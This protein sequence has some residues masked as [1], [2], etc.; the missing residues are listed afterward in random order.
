VTGV[1]DTPA[2][3]DGAQIVN[4]TVA[5][6]AAGS[7]NAWDSLAA[8]QVAVTN[9]DNDAPGFTLSKT[10]AAVSENGTTDTFTVV[11]NAQPLSNV[12]LDVSSANTDEVTASPAQVTFTP[13]N[14]D[15]PVIITV[16][17][18]ND[19][20][21]VV[22]GAQVVNVT[23]AVNAA[24]SDNAWDSLAAQQ[25]AVTNADNDAPGFTL[26]KTTA[27][28]SENGT[29]DTFTVVLNAQPLSN[30]VLD[31]SSANTDEVTASPAQVTFTPSNWDTPVIITV[32][33][34][35]DTPAVVDGAQ[36]VNVTVAVNA[37]GSDNAWD[38]LAAQQ[39][40][41]TNADNDAPGFTLSK[42]TAAVSENGTTDTFTVVLNAQPLS[43][44]VLDVSSANTDEV[45]AAPAQV[46][47][48]PSNWDTPV[49]ITVTG[50]NDT[51]AVV[52]GAQVVN[53]TVAVN[54]AGSD[55]AWDSLAAQQVAV[56]NADND[57]PGFTLSKTTAAVS[58]NGT[59]DTFTVVLNAQPL[60]NVV[61][62][63]SSANTDEVTA[64]PAQVT[65]T[66]SNWDTPVIITVTGVNDTPAVVDGAQV[67][68]VTVAVN[69]AGSDNAWDSLAAQQVAVTNAD[70]DAPGFTLSKTTAAVSENGTTDTFTVVLN[71]QP[72]SNVV[73]DVSSANTDEVTAA[74]VQVTFTPSNWDTPVVI[75]V[76]GVNDTPAVVDGA[77]VVNVT[78]AVNAAGS[79]NAW[80]SLAAQQVAVTNADN[81]A[82]GFTLSKTTAAVSENGTTDTFTVVLNAQPLSNVVLDV[83][84]ANTDEVTAAPAQVTFT[85]S[86]WDTPVVI[87]VTG[88][89]DTPA[90]V[91]GAQVVN[92]TVAVN[93]AGSDNA[94]DSLAAQQVAV[95]NADND[96]PG[97]TL[98]KTTAAVSE[99][100]T[101]DTFTVVLN[102]QPLSNVV[103]DVSSANTDEV[104]AAPA[105]VTFTPS[106][107]DTPVVI[108]VTGVNDTP[109]AVDGAQVVN[110]TVA[111]NA[112]GSDNAWD[113]LAAQQVAVTN[114]D[115]DAP[116]FTLSKT[117]AAVS[118]N[119]TTDTFTVVLNAQPLSNVVLDVSSANTDEV[120]AAPA[121]VTFT[122]SNWDT[123]V[124][125]TVT[126]VNDTPAVVDGAQV[127]N[128]T[129]AV[130]AAGSDNAWD[131]LAAQQVAVTNADNDDG[132]DTV[133]P[134][135]TI[136]QAA[137]QA[138]P[139]STAPIN[140]TVV[141][142]EPVTG[143]G[144]DDLILSG[145]APGALTA[146][147]TGSGTT[148]NVA[149]SGMSGSG[150][151]EAYVMVCAAMDAAGNQSEAST[152][153][154]NSVLYDGP[155]PIA[156]D[157][158]YETNEDTQL[159]VSLPGVLVNDVNPLGGSLTAKQ[160]TSPSH[161]YLAFNPA[162]GA[163]S[164]R[165]FDNYFGPDTFT[166]RA[167]NGSD[168]SAPATVTITVKPVN[169]PPVARDDMYTVRQNETLNVS[170]SGGVL[171]NDT[172]V[173]SVMEV[174]NV[175]ALTGGG[176]LNVNSTG[177]FTYAPGAFTGTATFTYEAW[178]DDDTHSTG[179][180]TIVVTPIQAGPAV[181]SVQIND[182][183]AQRS[184][185]NSLTVT[186]T[187]IVDLDSSA[188]KLVNKNTL[189]EVELGF[190]KSDA[191]GK[192]VVTLT[193]T[194]SGILGGSLAD[195]NYLLTIDLEKNG[196]GNGSD[197]QFGASETDKFFR[198]FG[199]S[200]GDRDVDSTDYF[201][202][203][204]ALN[205]TSASSKYLWF[206]D[207]DLD[208]DVDSSDMSSFLLNY[209][210][211]LAW[212]P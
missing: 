85:P 148:Y 195:G 184:M 139:A 107:W 86:N 69:A 153:T 165:P 146:V 179:T 180:V 101:T 128:V 84:S 132:G 189:A 130:N 81:D 168:Y 34:V 59:T 175:G 58:E 116:G 11:L 15:T 10:T 36:V 170:I 149:V 91:D 210:K 63:V 202:I 17:G 133:A 38:S 140:F 33:G 191:T 60:S 18:V 92:V 123:P 110:V 13:S 94:W 109:A 186:F 150:T 68:N 108:T 89:N 74:P 83:S 197:H 97:F 151:V 125:I 23:V 196:F 31:V 167:V 161:G 127:V 131:S 105:Q 185:I 49:I 66:P 61:L 25:V 62:D 46:T 99:N 164:Y 65:F 53:V 67:V 136:D 156:S 24:G 22:D 135:V 145:T 52:D 203:R 35:N 64:A 160:L 207:Y 117:T 55:N 115:N 138:D 192:S 41:V 27:A 194:G 137:D 90:V 112:A 204:G 119:G 144:A 129:V 30:V 32:T 206:F 12:V 50:V 104:T 152:S 157:D 9:A 122:P 182:G 37:A 113:S 73:L 103:L 76:T 54:A 111:V 5:V 174:R 159:V 141:F 200:D 3:V 205:Q 44:V 177:S 142:S 51:P 78:V 211:A 166:Y 2:V 7:D 6:N 181:E 72:L 77:Q 124:V 75:T 70:N 16:T 28:V 102:A 208:A 47:F 48:T 120:T 45:T 155:D 121:Q 82:P 43:N 95:T 198:F 201:R 39:V 57:A 26:S 42:T 183:S 176:T 178:D 1:N 158:S 190:V 169:D 14:W 199:D 134:T 88:V 173:D 187:S 212:I 118:E 171:A 126:G 20:P 93:A 21:A 8:Q 98:S 100:G 163:F 29:T 172:D 188:F 114:A 19:T 193:F 56:T 4:V 143:F 154:D 96:A 106:N 80:D 209:R 147:V 162:T 79:D 71:A 87:T 40:A